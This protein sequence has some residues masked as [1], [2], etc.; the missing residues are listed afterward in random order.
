[1][2]TAVLL[3]VRR[4]QLPLWIAHAILAAATVAISIEIHANV[5]P[6]NDDEILYLWVAVFVFYFLG[7]HAGLAHMALV[8]AGYWIAIFTNPTARS[9]DWLRWLIT[10]GTLAIVGLFVDHLARRQETTIHRLNQAVRS[11]PLTGLLNRNGFAEA[12]AVALASAQRR[13]ATFAVLISDL[14]RFKLVNDELRHAA[15]D[16]TLKSV[17][18]LLDQTTRG[19]DRAARLGGEESAVLA[20]DVGS[21]Q[22]RQTA[23]RVCERIEAAF[24]DSPVLG[25]IASPS[26]TRRPSSSSHSSNARPSAPGWHGRTG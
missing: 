11:D 5:R 19:S 2:A 14:D 12:F 8:A 16:E 22:A 18:T 13:D 21:E 6:A 23:E 3:R 1:M 15:G 26:P 20:S 10:V 7:R 24:A 17:A 25:P 4:R 9:E